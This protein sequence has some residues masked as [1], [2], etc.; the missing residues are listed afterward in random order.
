MTLAMTVHNN[1]AWITVARRMASCAPPG[2]LV[3]VQ[4]TVVAEDG[5]P[6]LWAKPTVTTLE[7]NKS[8]RAGL[9]LLTGIDL[10]WLTNV[11]LLDIGT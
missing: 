3:I 7:P 9:S 6:R 2:R 11:D 4:M 5:S 8:A 10:S 1:D